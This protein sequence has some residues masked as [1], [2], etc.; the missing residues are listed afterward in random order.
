MNGTSWASWFETALAR[1]P[2]MRIT[3]SREITLRRRRHRG[4]SSDGGRRTRHVAGRRGDARPGR[5][6]RGLTRG[7]RGR[8]PPKPPKKSRIDGGCGLHRRPRR[9]L[10]LLLLL[11]LLL[12]LL[13]R[14]RL[15]R[16]GARVPSGATL[17]TGDSPLACSRP[18]SRRGQTKSSAR[19]AGGASASPLTSVRAASASTAAGREPG[20]PSN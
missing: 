18:T 9:S 19:P 4:R 11:K 7:R 13:R 15:L 8:S 10:L 16:P 1:L 5:G 3:L 6:R 12:L 2:T 14:Q 17:A 20:P